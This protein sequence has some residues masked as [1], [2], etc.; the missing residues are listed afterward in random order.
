M[1][2]YAA[3]LDNKGPLPQ[4]TQHMHY[5]PALCMGVQGAKK[6]R[7]ARTCPNRLNPVFHKFISPK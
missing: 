5:T 7:L 6:I 4:Q 1:P 3:T 2:G